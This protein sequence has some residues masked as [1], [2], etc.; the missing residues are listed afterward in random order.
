MPFI[1][2]EIW[3]AIYDGKPPLRSIALA[4]YPQ[5]SESQIDANAE[6]EMSTLQEVIENV[7]NLRAELKVEQKLKV[8][9]AIYTADIKV[10][11]LIERN[12]GAVERLANV[13]NVTF[14]DE[15]KHSGSR[16]TTDFDV[17]LIYERKID[18]GA[19]RERLQK[20][21]ERYEKEISTG[22]R[23]LENEQF[24]AKAPKQ[25][26]DGIRKRSTELEVL[27]TKAQ[28]AL[29]ELT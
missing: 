19:E 6:R 9:A 21:L 27:R 25:V 11:D 28:T 1:S 17:R 24:L 23:Q 14:S 4:A 29:A 20:E 10:R 3:Y 7:R 15:S 18:I 22:A 2:E 26:I 16:S 12:R 13:D 5:S 8:P